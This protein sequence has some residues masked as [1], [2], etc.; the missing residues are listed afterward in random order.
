MQKTL[1]HITILIFI[2]SQLQ[3]N[4]Q[5]LLLDTLKPQHE[6]QEYPFIIIPAYYE[7]LSKKFG[8][9][10]IKNNDS[11]CLRLWTGSMFGY[12]LST[13]DYK[14]GY[15]NSRSYNYFSDTSIKEVKL[16]PKI[17]TSEF[18][19]QLLAF[20]FDKFISQYQIKGFQDN[21]DD[22][23]WYTLEIIKKKGYRV[24]Q[25]HSPESY[26]DNDN[27]QFAEL[28][29]MLDKFFLNNRD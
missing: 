16:N 4:G 10:E 28:I 29:K 13:F 15:W 9:S 22:G 24:F 17:S 14:N 23:T 5:A 1:R 7:Q 25:Y 3:T 11:F 18:L 6:R 26:E 21:V 27:K 8:L 20:N 2:A 19:N 12:N